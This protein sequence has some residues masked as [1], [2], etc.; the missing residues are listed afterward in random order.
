[1]VDTAV[2]KALAERDAVIAQAAQRVSLWAKEA[3]DALVAEGVF[4]GTEPGG[5]LTRE[6]A[7]TVIQSLNK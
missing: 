2:D 1:M 6:Q 4:D 7:A 5:V 3:W